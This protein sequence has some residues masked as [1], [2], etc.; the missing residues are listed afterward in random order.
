MR[1]FYKNAGLFV[2]NSDEIIRPPKLPD[3][4]L[5]DFLNLTITEHVLYHHVVAIFCT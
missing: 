5:L 4:A 3:F 2:K 1:S